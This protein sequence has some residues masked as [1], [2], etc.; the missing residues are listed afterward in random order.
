MRKQYHILNGDSLKEQFPENIQGEILVARECL[1]DGNVNG[2]SLIDFF[3]VRA[4][5]ISNNY[6]GF[7]EQDYFEKTVPE[8]QKI[9]N[10]PDNVDI[11]LWFEDDLFCQVNFWFVINL[12][13]KSNK[14]NKLFLIRPKSHSQYGFGGLLKSELIS[15]F[16]NRLELTELDKLSLLWNFYQI[17]DTEKLIETSRQLKNLYPFIFTAVN[18]HFERIPTN[19]SM[20]RPSQSLVQIMEELNTSEFG[21]I[22]KEFC[23]REY[24]Y[25][26]GDLQVKRLLDEINNNC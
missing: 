6:D 3:K 21:P 18:A 5:F 26:F 1:V 17:N 24:I 12:L 15:I 14:N 25:G 4:E 22:F 16:E 9:Q 7:K 13:I 19:G 11:N 10:I 23:K 20:G 8:F 2:N